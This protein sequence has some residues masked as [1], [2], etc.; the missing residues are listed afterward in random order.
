MSRRKYGNVPT[1]VDGRRFASRREAARYCELRLLERAG[2]IRHLECQV[3]YRLT[4]GGLLVCRY[5]ADFRYTEA[6]GREVVEDAKGYRTPEY[7]LKA[8]LMKA[9]HGITV[10]EV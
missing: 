9:V 1:E 8:K 4:V 5:V 10:V 7:K 3:P 2:A 6:D